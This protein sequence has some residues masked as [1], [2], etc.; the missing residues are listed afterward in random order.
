MSLYKVAALSGGTAAAVGGGVLVSKSLLFQSS[1]TPKVT[2]KDRLQK[3]GYSLDLDSSK[4]NTIHEEYK[5]PNSVSNIKFSSEIK[6]AQGL[7]KECAAYLKSEDDNS[8]YEI[9]KRWCVDPRKVSD[10]LTASGFKSLKTEGEDDKSKWEKLEGEYAKDT[11]KKINGWKFSKAKDENTW[12]ELQTKC[13][14]LLDLN[15][16][17]GDYEMAMRE[18]KSWCTEEGV[19]K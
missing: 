16:W 6:D 18:T 9:S 11:S 14:A 3:A 4:W 19:P 10:F 7:E 12:K 2:I 13:K 15:P 17:S 1:P 8:K 5:K